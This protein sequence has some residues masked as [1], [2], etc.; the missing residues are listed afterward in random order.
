MAQVNFVNTPGTSPCPLDAAVGMAYV[1]I[2]F[3][4]IPGVEELGPGLIYNIAPY[5]DE[6]AAFAFNIVA[7]V[8]L[9]VSVR[10]DSDYGI[11]VTARNL[12]EAVPIAASNVTFWGVPADHN[13][14]GPEFDP[15]SGRLFGGP[16]SGVREPF[17]M[18]PTHCSPDPLISHVGATTWEPGVAGDVDQDSI[19]PFTGCEKLTFAPSLQVT[20]DNSRAGAPAGYAVDIDLPFDSA[21]DGVG[22][23]TLRDAQVTLPRGVTL[24]PGIADGLQ[25]CSDQQL[26]LHDLAPE[27]CPQASKIGTASITSPLVSDPL[28]GAVYVGEPK[29]GNRYRMFL[30]L[31][32]N[33]VGVKLEGK[34][35]PDPETGQLTATFEN[36][37]QLPFTN[38]HLQLKGGPHAVLVNPPSC[39]SYSSRGEFNS[40]ASELP[41]PATAPLTIDAGC[42]QGGAFAPAL[43]AGTATRPAVRSLPSSSR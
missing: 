41:V 35:S 22:A 23:S 21:A 25:G 33:G 7:P 20:P 37:P 26:G 29:P 32:G 36:N 24:S 28:T 31:A 43:R 2:K 10:S 11:T 17:L 16:G 4:G 30:A 15:S 12:A 1:S 39:G 18:N 42:S 19:G 9:D 8:R 27:Q 38:V 34:V 6:P 40:W 14:P 13:G 3:E 5:E